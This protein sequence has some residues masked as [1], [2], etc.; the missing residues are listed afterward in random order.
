M[1]IDRIDVGLLAELGRHVDRSSTCITILVGS[2]RLT[3]STAESPNGKPTE[4]GRIFTRISLS[5][6]SA[7]ANP[8]PR[9][10]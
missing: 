6:R 9:D 10:R 1:S 4:I 3:G 2:G 8:I 5:N 7:L